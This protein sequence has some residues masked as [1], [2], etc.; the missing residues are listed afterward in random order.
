MIH[1]KKT[2]IIALPSWTNLGKVLGKA[3]SNLHRQLEGVQSRRH[4]RQM[5]CLPFDDGWLLEAIALHDFEPQHSQP[6]D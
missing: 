5:E 2:A 1:E 6:C 4:P 3:A